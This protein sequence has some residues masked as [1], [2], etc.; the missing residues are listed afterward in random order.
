MTLNCDIAVTNAL[1]QFPTMA[2]S[3]APNGLLAKAQPQLGK[4]ELACT[5]D[6]ETS[7][8]APTF[9]PNGLLNDASATL[10]RT[11]VSKSRS[12]SPVTLLSNSGTSTPPTEFVPT[13]LLSSSSIVELVTAPVNVEPLVDET[14]DEGGF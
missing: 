11:R 14:M 8:L 13:G 2:L 1:R 7:Q 5:V 3:F 9:L 10:V 4:D 12:T 6:D